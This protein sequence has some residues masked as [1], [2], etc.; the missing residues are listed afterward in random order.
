MQ[1]ATH[2]SHSALIIFAPAG[3]GKTL[4]LVQRVIHLI[5]SGL[6][7]ESV[8][9]LTF[10]RKAASELSARLATATPAPV[11]VRTFH[12][13]C[14]RL[15]RMFN[16][17]L[18]ESGLA[19]S[20]QQLAFVGNALRAW[21][22]KHAEDR[23]D[24]DNGAELSK[25][26]RLALYRRILRCIGHARLRGLAAAPPPLQG[27]FGTFVLDHYTQ[28][29]RTARLLD[30]GELQELVVQL[31]HNPQVVQAVQRRYRHILVDEYQDTNSQQLALLRMVRHHSSET[32]ATG[33][34][35]GITVVGDDD[36]SIYSFRGAEP[37]IFQALRRHMP[38]CSTATLSQNY[39]SSG[40]I[41]HAASA[42][43][44]KN[45]GRISKRAWTANADGQRI[46]VC[47]CANAACEMDW[48]A[49]RILDMRK[50]NTP[51]SDMAILYRTHAIGRQLQATLRERRVPLRSATTDV[52][53]RPDMAPIVSLLRLLC[54]PNDSS[55]FPAVAL[56]CQPPLSAQLRAAIA[57]DAARRCVSQ[58]ASAR[59]LHAA[60]GP[61]PPSPA[62]LDAL[63]PLIA[64]TAAHMQGGGRAAL[65]AL[66]QGIDE[67]VYSARTL[68]PSELLQAV[69]ES[70]LAGGSRPNTAPQGV[71]LLSDE[72]T[73]AM[74]AF[75]PNDLSSA[76]TTGGAVDRL[77]VLRDFMEHAALCEFED[78]PDD[79]SKPK[80]GTNGVTLSTMH[81]A[82]GLEWPV[83]FIVRCNED[84]IPLNA[85]MGDDE[86]SLSLMQE[87]RRLLYVAMT[88]ARSNLFISYLMLRPDKQLVAISSFLQDVPSQHR[89]N[90]Q[91]MSVEHAD[92]QFGTPSV[93]HRVPSRSQLK[94]VST[95]SQ[96]AAHVPEAIGEQLRYW[97]QVRQE[98]PPP[99]ARTRKPAAASAAKGK[100]DSAAKRLRKSSGWA[101]S[102]QQ[103]QHDS[104]RNA[105]RAPAN[106]P[107]RAREAS[108]GR[109]RIVVSDEDDFA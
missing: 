5:V 76:S 11:E 77:A 85:S 13:W 78:A 3:A 33:L 57:D 26:R 81:G 99:A 65:H 6:S 64:S 87:E 68:P 97:Q 56:A 92:L 9:C 109:R 71:R 54:H 79:G 46:V 74:D 95:A 34:P 38:D 89:L 42:L 41:L 28:S 31:L 37:G 69:L 16:P 59:A 49:A 60:T 72:L 105:D 39:R 35:I 10:T 107:T 20:S 96:M 47:E 32:S 93:Q 83:V 102:K 30:I 75:E 106:D 103:Q 55:S 18:C 94:P 61:L 66:L 4:T 27:A 51:F 24:R 58:L 84:T 25:E 90:M 7:S 23:D 70:G 104:L 62:E 88:R 40:H 100:Q 53:R 48:I 86:L 21:Q 15:I 36:Q 82:K 101:S 80:Q 19:A 29:L 43:V 17:Q 2:E 44:S 67:L 1:A 52:F 8:L 12:A 50:Q 98:Q 45:P 63:R 73:A 22:M 108:A 91:H 14:L